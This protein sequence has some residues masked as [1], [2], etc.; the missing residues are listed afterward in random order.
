[1]LARNASCCQWISCCGWDTHCH[2][3]YCVRQFTL[4]FPVYFTKWYRICRSTQVYLSAELRF[5]TRV[6]FR[7]VNIWAKQRRIS[8]HSSVFQTDQIL[9]SYLMSGSLRRNDWCKDEISSDISLSAR[10]VLLRGNLL[11]FHDEYKVTSRAWFAC[12]SP[13]PTNRRRQRRHVA[14]W[15]SQDER[16]RFKEKSISSF[17]LCSH[18][19]AAWVL[20]TFHEISIFSLSVCYTSISGWT[21]CCAR[22]LRCLI[23]IGKYEL[24]CQGMAV[25]LGK[26]DQ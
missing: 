13:W 9:A 4:T 1:M 16:V 8:G 23:S 3:I 14:L 26:F 11:S 7:D 21:S 6:R 24:G 22:N 20:F 18:L 19:C 10:F 15:H 2:P 5:H 25:R 12:R 17:T